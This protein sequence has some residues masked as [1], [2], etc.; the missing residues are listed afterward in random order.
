MS[1]PSLGVGVVRTWGHGSADRSGGA[2]L[3]L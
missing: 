3:M 1:Q 2:G